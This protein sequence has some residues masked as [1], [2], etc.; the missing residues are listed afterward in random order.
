M[1]PQRI[2]RLASAL[3]LAAC[4]FSQPSG[5]FAPD[6]GTSPPPAAATGQP[7]GWD[8]DLRLRLAEDRNPD[9]RTVEVNIEARVSQVSFLP[10]TT[11]PAWT[12]DG[13]V[14]GPMIRANVGDRVIVNFTNNLPEETTIHWHGLRI[15]VE[16]DGVPKH[17][18]PAIRPGETFRYDFT[19]PDAG[20]FWYHPHFH[21]T[22]QVGDGLYGTLLVDDPKELAGFGDSVVLQLS[23]MSID[24]KGRLSAHD[25]GGMFSTL[26]GREGGALL[27]N[28]KLNPVLR[29]R[30][31]V[32]QRWR[33]VNS[34]RSR[35]FQ[36]SL[37][38]HKFVRIG[39]DGGLIGRAI[40]LE[41]LVIIPGE[42]VDVVVV[43]T[44]QPG[45]EI[46]M[47]WV[48]YDRGYGTA[49]NRPEEPLMRFQL[50]SD[51]AVS[52]PQLPSPTRVIAPLDTKDVTEV[53]IEFTR[54]DI[55]GKFF[56][57]I[58]GIPSGHDEP[59]KG[60]TGETQVWT[61]GNRIDWDHP[62]HLHGFFFQ[63]LNADGTP[64]EPIEWKDTVNVPVKKQVKIAIKY[65]DRPG[66]W[67]FHCHILD[68]A[69]AG[70]M[71]MLELT[72]PGAPSHQP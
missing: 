71:G 55:D 31:G 37:P 13:G 51:G 61:I 57:G 22:A 6:S 69:D 32:P 14:P 64:K 29:A 42:R 68:H 4:S 39:G 10:G 18:G 67:M 7:K 56:L 70:M 1:Y 49:F 38:G 62:F 24:E 52:P 19:V 44:G 54:N 12:Y 40:E 8:D 25:A 66:M 17:S 48:P 2:T 50:A 27:V 45:A 58:N 3:L 43:P 41:Q 60:Q 47:R 23:D 16:M 65:D 36:L 59:F 21:S 28:G 15:P 5:P 53:N 33:I 9:P 20:L 63:V 30:V 26:F 72:K 11:T 34:A 46:S 35:Y